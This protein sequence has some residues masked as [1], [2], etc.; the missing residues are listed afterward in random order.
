MCCEMDRAFEEF[1]SAEDK[2]PWGPITMLWAMWHASAE[3]EG[4]GQ[5]GEPCG[6]RTDNRCPF[7]L[8]RRSRSDPCPRKGPAIILQ[9]HR[10]S[11]IL[12]VSIVFSDVSDLSIEIQHNRSDPRYPARFS[13][14]PHRIRQGEQRLCWQ[15]HW[16][17][18][19]AYARR[20]AQAVYRSRKAGQVVRMCEMWAGPEC[21]A[22]TL[23]EKAA[24]GVV[25]SIKG[26]SAV[27]LGERRT[28]D[29]VSHMVRPLRK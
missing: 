1:H 23:C 6:Y 24:A 2:S 13:I 15:R 3:L 12:G 14:S 10:P 11:N 7:F 16:L 5:Q 26:E 25:F 20:A 4:Y 18:G 9:L 28:D 21:K 29:S 19:T 27:Q 17:T 22:T 8:S